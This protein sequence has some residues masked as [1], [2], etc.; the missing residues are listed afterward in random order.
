ME[1]RLEE[2]KRLKREEEMS[3]E[4]SQNYIDDLELSIKACEAALGAKTEK[5]YVMVKS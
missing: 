1:Q 5:G 3:A 4:P 2:L